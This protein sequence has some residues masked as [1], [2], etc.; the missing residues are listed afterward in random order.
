MHA[1]QFTETDGGY[2]ITGLNAA[3]NAFAGRRR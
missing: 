1:F 2:D 3:L